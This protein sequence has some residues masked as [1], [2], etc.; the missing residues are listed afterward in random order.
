[1]Y[2]VERK[3][4]YKWKV[5]LEKYYPKRLIKERTGEALFGYVYLEEEKDETWDVYVTYLYLFDETKENILMLV[6]VRISDKKN[7]G[8]EA[9]ISIPKIRDNIGFPC[10]VHIKKS[11]GVGLMYMTVN[12][13]PD[14]TTFEVYR[15]MLEFKG[16]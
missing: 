2:L 9:S 13:A 12:E 10:P 14:T 7:M 3:T 11:L 6:P 8:N 4:E 5:L 1:M 15:M 16:R